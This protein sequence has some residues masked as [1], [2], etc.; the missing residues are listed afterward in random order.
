[1]PQLAQ[2]KSPTT[3]MDNRKVNRTPMPAPSLA[4]KL[5]LQLWLVLS[6]VVE[7]QWAAA[8]AMA[9]HHHLRPRSMPST[10]RRS[11]S[12][13]SAKIIE[14]RICICAKQYDTI[15]SRWCSPPPVRATSIVQNPASYSLINQLES[16]GIIAN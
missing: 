3:S 12:I 13:C 8:V 16:S 6:A 2:A 15:S 10:L 14:T 5:V 1:M 4:N 9:A 11:W 7:S